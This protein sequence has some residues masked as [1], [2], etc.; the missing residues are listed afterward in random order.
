MAWAMGAV[1]VEPSS[2]GR[3]SLVNTKGSAVPG[4]DTSPTEVSV[5]GLFG[6]QETSRASDS[7][8]GSS[9]FHCFI[10]ILL[11]KQGVSCLEPLFPSPRLR[12][13]AG[14][15]HYYTAYSQ[16]NISISFQSGY[17]PVT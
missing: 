7:R 8:A 15:I 11:I 14:M 12:E 2:R 4:A 13:N 9:F 17:K 3:L 10:V 1:E 6:P 5:P 16:K